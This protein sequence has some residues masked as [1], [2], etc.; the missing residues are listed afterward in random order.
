MQALNKRFAKLV[1]MAP[2]TIAVRHQLAFMNGKTELERGLKMMIEGAELYC[3]AME[4]QS[5]WKIG[6]D[7]VL[8]P[9]MGAIL[10]G[11]IGLL[12]G[13]GFFDGGTIDGA[14]RDIAKEYEI[15]DVDQ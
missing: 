11:I 4:K 6:K 9:E 13:P 5:D 10:N 8:G 2:N 1:K 3:R 12:N 14:I 15:E 7:Y